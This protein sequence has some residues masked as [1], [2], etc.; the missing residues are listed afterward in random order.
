MVLFKT[1]TEVSKDYN[2]PL[3]TVYYRVLKH[4]YRVNDYNEIL[5]SDVEAYEKKGIKA[6]RPKGAK[7][8]YPRKKRK[9][10]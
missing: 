3:S 7:D 6:G 9:E 4:H 2:I 5:V 1:V 8:S 10:I